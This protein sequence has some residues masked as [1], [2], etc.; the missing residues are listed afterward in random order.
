M[1]FKELLQRALAHESLFCLLFVS[2]PLI[3]LGLMTM[4]HQLVLQFLP[5]AQI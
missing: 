2:D 1:G 5:L 3:S 4:C